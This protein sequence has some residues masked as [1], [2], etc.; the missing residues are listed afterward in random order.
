[1]AARGNDVDADGA[2]TAVLGSV[3]RIVGK[4]VLVADV[5]SNLLADR[6]DVFDVFREV[7]YP[8]GG[9]RDGD[10]SLAGVLG[11]LLGFLAEQ[12]DGVNDRVGLLN[13]L[14]SLLERVT[15]G[16]VFAVGDD[17]EDF[18]LFVTL[19]E[20]IERA[21]DSVVESGA[22][23][24]VD[25]LKGFLQFRNVVGEVL[26]EVEVEVIVE[27]DDESFVLG[28]AVLDESEGSLVDAGTL[29]AHAAAIVDD[30][31][32]TDGNIFALEDGELLLDLIFVDAEILLGEAVNE[33]AAVV[34]NAG[35]KN[36]E[37]DVELDFATGLGG[38]N[39]L[40]R[41]RGRSILNRNLSRRTLPEEDEREEN[42]ESEIPCYARNDGVAEL[43]SGRE[44]NS[45]S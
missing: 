42:G 12:A 40:V 38:G 2:V 8:T 35:V 9:L 33:F 36:D 26:V 27:I 43:A 18:L 5:V 1:M 20:V 7:G 14:H 24:R 39:G 44:R 23:A 6:M 29:V 45:R 41:R 13:F 22:A 4:R 28:I 19:F 34:E 11:R 37:V 30:Q 31:A 15:A 16:V 10:E 32:H 3:R 17:E 21:D 25:A